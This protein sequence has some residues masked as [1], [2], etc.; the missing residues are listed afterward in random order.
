MAPRPPRSRKPAAPR[1]AA[2]SSRARASRA[3][4]SGAAARSRSKAS[5]AAQDTASH[6]G[7]SH[8]GASVSG[9]S[10][11]Y[12]KYHGLGNDYLVIEPGRFRAPLSAAQ[13]RA[14]CDRHRGIGA[15]GV[16]LGPLTVERPAG[17]AADVPALRIF[18]PDG[19]EGEKSGNGLRIF[20]RHLWERGLVAGRAFSLH[21]PG[22]TVHV[23]VLDAGGT[24]IAIAMGAVRFDSAHIPMRGPPREVLR[25]PLQV[26]EATY[27]VNGATIGNPHCVVLVEAPTPAL[28][29][30]VGPLIER[31][32]SFPQRTNVQF[33][34][35]L[36]RHAIQ[37]E[38]WER[39]AGYTQASGTS[40]CASAA[41][42]CR[43][44]LCESPVT[45]HM[46]GG[47]LEV[48]LGAGFEAELEGDVAAVGCGRLA[49][50]FLAAHGLRRA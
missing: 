15:D 16:L 29:Q 45:V 36:D 47:R 7:A 21:T 14:L 5:A 37:I 32:A 31:H 26:G 10:H 3:A 12:C 35:V 28:A 23:R 50:E 34:R 25:E 9:A 13:G 27:T 46:P 48:R 44:G 17:L 43:L 19:S 24:R 20:A 6:D 8:G 42:A 4:S 49:D 2:P 39:G 41:V 11:D 22:G 30:S 40:S 18:N 1:K 33:M 38:I